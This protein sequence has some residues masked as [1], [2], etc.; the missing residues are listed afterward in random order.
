MT[1]YLLHRCAI[2]ARRQGGAIEGTAT[3]LIFPVAAVFHVVGTATLLPDP[4]VAGCVFK[5]DILNPKS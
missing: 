3:F 4:R 1:A 5:A 2:E